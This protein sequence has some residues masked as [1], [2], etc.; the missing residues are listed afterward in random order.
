[1]KT[2]LS[3]KGAL[4]LFES[5]F[6]DRETITKQEC[7]NFLSAAFI[8]AQQPQREVGGIEVPDQVKQ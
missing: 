3:R 5:Y 1:M 4:T 8:V 2:I 7:L 6:G